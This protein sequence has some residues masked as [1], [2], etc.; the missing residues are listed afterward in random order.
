VTLVRYQGAHAGT[1][2]DYL[3]LATSTT[4]TVEPGGVYDVAPASGRMVPGIPGGCVVLEGYDLAHELKARSAQPES[5]SG[6]EAAGE[7]AGGEPVAEASD[8]TG[9]EPSAEA[10]E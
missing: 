4:L 6:D 9:P 5:G 1:L 2:P 10:G 7:S 8:E 3:D